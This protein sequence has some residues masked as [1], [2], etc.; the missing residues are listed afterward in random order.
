MGALLPCAVLIVLSAEIVILLIHFH[1]KKVSGQD[2]KSDPAT[3]AEM[4]KFLE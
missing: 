3:E 1:D 2:K 4:K